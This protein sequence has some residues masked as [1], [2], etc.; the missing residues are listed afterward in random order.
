MLN[1]LELNP[2]LFREV[3]S[4]FRTHNIVIVV[5]CSLAMQYVFYSM[6]SGFLVYQSLDFLLPLCLFLGGFY[7]ISTDLAREEQRGTLNF[8]RLSPQSSQSILLGKMLGV[9][10]LIYLGVALGI[11]LHFFGSL[12]EGVSL[13]GILGKYVF[14]IA[15]CWL[16][17]SFACLYTLRLSSSQKNFYNPQAIA[18]L[19]LIITGT[20]V[21]P[22]LSFI[23]LFITPDLFTKVDWF[24]LD[25]GSDKLLDCFWLLTTIVGATYFIWKAVNRRFRDPNITLVSKSQS[26]QLMILSQVWLMG[27]AF[28][29]TDLSSSFPYYGFGLAWVYYV[30]PIVFFMLISALSP[31]HQTLLDWSRYNHQSH[32]RK[33]G[34]WNDLI[35]G[36]KSPNIVA[37]AINL[38]ITAVIWIPW[39]LSLSDRV[40]SDMS[41]S[42]PE[43][44]LGLLLT[45]G[46]VSIYAVSNQ[47][48]TIK[49]KPR[50][51]INLV[52]ALGCVIVILPLAIAGVLAADNVQ[53]S[54]LWAVSPFPVFC[55]FLGTIS[56]AI[57]GLGLQLTLLGFLTK[58]LTKQIQKVGA[59]KTQVLLT[60]E[61]SQFK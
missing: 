4:R 27:F 2:Q 30:M 53:I 48:L 5:A 34:L 58:Q 13:G 61:T 33:Q 56:T 40:L 32:T 42:K 7:L 23:Y 11:P 31:S 41:L 12:V 1:V 51:R 9:P 20:F 19:G 57:L 46:I 54:L 49:F 38:L 35:W 21:S 22:Y 50:S 14:W 17:Y 15:G 6:S 29:R 26:Y 55:V 43:A 45:M 52:A 24:F 25:L 37:I 3:K 44:V 59:S 47:Q 28:S 18:G 16:F 8:I 39:L 36:E 10:S 60:A